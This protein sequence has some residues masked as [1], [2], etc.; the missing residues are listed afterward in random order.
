[1]T[2]VDIIGDVG[3]LSESLIPRLD[4]EELGT[5]VCKIIFFGG[6]FGNFLYFN[7]FLTV[8]DMK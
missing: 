2:I 6:N 7:C 4:F 3:F 8:F 5:D 1:M